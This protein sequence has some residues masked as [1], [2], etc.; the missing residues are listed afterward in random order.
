MDVEAVLQRAAARHAARSAQHAQHAQHTA[1]TVAHEPSAHQHPDPLPQ[2]R[3]HSMRG[4]SEGSGSDNDDNVD[5]TG[6]ESRRAAGAVDEDCNAQQQMRWAV[7][8]ET[9]EEQSSPVQGGAAP[10]GLCLLDVF[11]GVEAAVIV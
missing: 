5:E 7:R 3:E 2:L 1:W 10:P 8:G 6:S 11:A 9:E 4:E